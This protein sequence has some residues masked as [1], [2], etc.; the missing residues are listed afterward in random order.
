M[1][2]K[3]TIG[4]KIPKDMLP[5]IQKAMEITGAI[6]ISDLLRD[7]LREYLKQLSLLSDRIERWEK[8]GE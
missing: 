2:E 6:S 3:I 7:A 1:S 4:C 8:N 5:A